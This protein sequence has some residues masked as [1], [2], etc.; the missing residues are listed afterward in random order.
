MNTQTHQTATTQFVEAGGIRFAY[1]RFGK[2]GGVPLVFLM[3]FTGTM[4]YWDP[5]IT[6]GFAEHREVILFNNAGVSNS[7]GTVPFTM[8]EMAADAATFVRGL[9]LEQ[10]DILG[11]SIGG[12][13]AQAFALNE[14][15]LCR[16]LILVGTGPRAG[17]GMESLSPEAQAIFSETYEEPELV[18]LK[19]MFSPSEKSQKAG[20]DW[21][22]RFRLRSENRDPENG[23][24][25]RTAQLAAV[26][27]W[28]AP[29]PNHLDYLKDIHQPTMI[30]N[31]DNDVIVYTIN[32]YI[33]LQNIPDAT[34]ILFPDANHGSQYQYPEDFVNY[35]N[36][37]LSK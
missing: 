33:M 13:V 29:R 27:A 30:V 17:E 18:W 22:K 16:K 21:L 12:F 1:R 23:D 2:T 20:Q 14:P 5:A 6:D 19:I 25:V 10:V 4:D 35:V 7:S 3:H 32:S 8:E 37:F 9:G 34:L 11:F 26:N 36:Y 31:G 15:R 24:E 28:G